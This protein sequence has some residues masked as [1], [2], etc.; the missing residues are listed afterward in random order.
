VDTQAIAARLTALKERFD[1]YYYDTDL[2]VADM[3]FLLA[4]VETLTQQVAA[5]KDELAGHPV[6]KTEWQQLN[7]ALAAERQMRSEVA[8]RAERAEQEN[9]QLRRAYLEARVA[10][11][12]AEQQ[13]DAAHA[14]LRRYEQLINE[15]KA[16]R[17]DP[18]HE[19]LIAIDRDKAAARV[20]A[21]DVALLKGIGC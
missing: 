4:H 15:L 1:N 12:Q 21:A 14:A 10:M 8:S 17:L 2:S 11:C 6:L 3:R 16:A 19:S 9:A 18:G 13:R 20:L 7:E 5:L